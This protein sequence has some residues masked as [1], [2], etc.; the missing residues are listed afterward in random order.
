MPSTSRTILFGGSFD[1]VHLGH[2]VLAQAALKAIDA[3]QLYFVPARCSP[4]KTNAVTDARHRVRML[5]LALADDP[6]LTVLE[7]ELTR[8]SP[9]YTADTLRWA[10][11]AFANSEIH[12][13]AGA[14]VL[15][16]LHLWREIMDILD[17]CRFRVIAR[18][19][20]KLAVPPVLANVIGPTRT[21]RLE[22]DFLELST[23]DIASTRI[24]SSIAA[25][26][27]TRVAQ[28]LPD[29]VWAY[30]RKHHLYGT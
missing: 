18:P 7:A 14:D 27:I 5:T 12:F 2:L 15:E 30:I 20:G 29:N 6:T 11:D 17:N 9:S 10:K 24:R 3:S 16:E 23:P 28:M 19:G 4:H 25:G 26:D 21:Q 22:A 1:P 8:E 13:L